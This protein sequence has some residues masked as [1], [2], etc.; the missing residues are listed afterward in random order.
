MNHCGPSPDA[1]HCAWSA[2]RSV[3]LIY[4]ESFS[5]NPFGGCLRR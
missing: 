3:F 5:Q 2:A 4:V 1:A